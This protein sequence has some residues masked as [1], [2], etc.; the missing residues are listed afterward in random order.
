MV[1]KLL[2]LSSS[3][4]NF[5]KH[6][7]K[8]ALGFVTFQILPDETKYDSKLYDGKNFMKK[9]K[10]FFSTLQKPNLKLKLRGFFF[11]S[12][13]FFASDILFRERLYLIPSPPPSRL[14]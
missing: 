4:Y 13:F 6:C 11:F 12:S 9:K 7:F 2:L 3:T 8:T 14:L 10:G 1:Y 5:L